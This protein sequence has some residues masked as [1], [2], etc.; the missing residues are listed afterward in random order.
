MAHAVFA[1]R[2]SVFGVNVRVVPV[3]DAMKVVVPHP[4]VAGVAS[5]PSVM[6]GN[7]IVIASSTAI[8]TVQLNA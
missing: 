2:L 5:E 4:P 8:G 7:S 6:D 1:A 3:A